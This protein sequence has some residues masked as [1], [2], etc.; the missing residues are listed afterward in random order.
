MTHRWTG[1]AAVCKYRFV[2]VFEQQQMTW[3]HPAPGHACRNITVLRQGYVSFSCVMSANKC[4]MVSIPCTHSYL[5]SLQFSVSHIECSQYHQVLYGQDAVQKPHL[6]AN[7]HDFP[8]IL[9]NWKYNIFKK[10]DHEKI[11]RNIW[12]YSN[13]TWKFSQYDFYH[14]SMA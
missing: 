12:L 9:I 14:K 10:I 3:C 11:L 13:M 4:N 1:M 6:H 2:V 8:E 7:L 5:K